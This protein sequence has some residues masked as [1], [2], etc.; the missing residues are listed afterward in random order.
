MSY[1]SLKDGIDRSLEYL[2]RLD[3]STLFR[4]G[5]DTFTASHI[6]KSMKAF[7]EL[8]EQH[9]LADELAEA[10]ETSFWVYASDANKRQNG[11]LF[12]GYY[13]PVLRGSLH[14]SA[15][16][17]YPIYRKPDDWVRVNL[18]LFGSQ[19]A[20]ERIVGRNVDQNIV[21]YFSRQEIDSD[22][23]LS[24]KGCEILWVSDRFELFSLHIQGSGRV[25]LEDGAELCVS[26]AG[27][28]GRPYRSIG[29]LLIDEE[30]ISADEI[31]M[32]RLRSYVREHPEDA[33]RVFNHNESYVFF[34]LVDE[35]PVGA[36]GVALTP[37]RSVATDS[38]LFP[39][40]SL[41]F[42][43]TEQPQVSED[44]VIESWKT[45]GRFVVNQDTGGAIKGPGRADLFWGSGS[46]AEAAAG[47]MQ[48]R[49]ELYFLVLKEGAGSQ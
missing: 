7:E 42:I 23:R 29:R 32:Q 15:R 38:R 3:D 25:L 45:F 39:R 14:P 43:R 20:G 40:G 24:Q 26:Y 49:G 2:N 13:E 11:V 8:I 47:H 34:R 21:P 33:E 30:K 35:G 41:A 18:G 17:P 6:V 10:I 36:I 44:G 1:G 31:S 48:H 22:R 19:Y 5:P 37:G 12:T 4:F 27:T 28:N 9:P 46:Y 16:Y